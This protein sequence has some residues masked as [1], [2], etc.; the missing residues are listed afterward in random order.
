MSKLIPDSREA[1]AVD[2]ERRGMFRRAITVWREIMD[3]SQETSVRD[4]CR[5]RIRQCYSYVR[6]SGERGDT[7]YLSGQ[8]SGD[9][10]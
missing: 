10:L 6:A 5:A 1:V 4:A 2:L 9:E 7:W 8:F 3:D